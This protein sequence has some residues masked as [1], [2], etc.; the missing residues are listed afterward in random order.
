[1][2]FLAPEL[3][4]IT[5]CQAGIP[6]ATAYH[7]DN[8]QGCAPRSLV[9]VAAPVDPAANPTSVS[10]LIRSRTLSWYEHNVLTEVPTAAVGEGCLVYPAS[11]QLLGLGAYLGRHLREGSELAREVAH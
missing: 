3:N 2:R 8:G 10:R 11:M 5:L 7:S 6:V 4:V 9:L 1:M